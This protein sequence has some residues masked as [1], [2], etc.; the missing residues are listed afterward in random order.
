M[1]QSPEH[2]PSPCSHTAS[3]EAGFKQPSVFSSAHL[4]PGHFF[5]IHIHIALSKCGVRSKGK[6]E[7]S[8]SAEE[9]TDDEEI[10]FGQ[11]GCF[12]LKLHG[13]L[14]DQKM[15]RCTYD[16]LKPVK[17]LDLYLRNICSADYWTGA[18]QHGEQHQGRFSLSVSALSSYI[19]CRR[20]QV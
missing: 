10:Y 3:E 18:L 17:P 1:R 14:R 20:H 9:D 19:H 12:P 13:G 15:Y 5:K 6:Q 2:K 7:I 8:W 4:S 11:G 16:P